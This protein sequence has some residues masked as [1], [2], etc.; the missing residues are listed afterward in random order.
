MNRRTPRPLATALQSL[1]VRLA[2]RT[3]LAAVQSAWTDVV[4]EAV[5]AHCAPVAERGGVLQV[6]CDEAVWAAELELLAPELLERLA[7]VATGAQITAL[8]CRA[9][10]AQRP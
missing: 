8:R 6:A 5:A 9:D 1:T 2:P 7:A 4:G 3:P 10:L